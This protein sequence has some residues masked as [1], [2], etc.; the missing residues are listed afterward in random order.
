MTDKT[1][2]RDVASGIYNKWG[3]PNPFNDTPRIK[4]TSPW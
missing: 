4:G 3:E 2:F 1:N